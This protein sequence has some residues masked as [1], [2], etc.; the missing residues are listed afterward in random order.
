MPP[1]GRPRTRE[2]FRSAAERAVEKNAPKRRRTFREFL[3]AEIRTDHGKYS[4]SGHRALGQI[5]DE[6]SDV[7]L[8]PRPEI[9]LDILKAE[10]LGLT[11]IGIGFSV[12]AAS[13]HGMNVGYFLP[14][15]NLAGRFGRTK[16]NPA[17]R[18]S[19]GIKRRMRDADDRRGTNQST[20]KEIFDAEG[21]SHFVYALGLKS[22]GNAVMI[23][24]DA[25]IDDEV[26]LIP[27]ENQEWSRGRLTHSPLK[28]RMGISVGMHPGEGIDLRYSEGCQYRWHIRCP[29]CR[30]DFLPEEVFPECVFRAPERRGGAWFLGCVKCGRP[31]DADADGHWFPHFPERRDDGLISYRI[32]QLSVPAISLGWIMS[33]WE[34]AQKKS[35]LMRKFNCAVLARPD[36]GSLEPISEDVLERATGSHLLARA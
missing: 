31:V 27:Q 24:L 34:D 17:I 6:L 16:I 33:R 19:P 29:G 36:A 35:S 11:T 30:K 12:W 23:P 8:L 9:R 26:D 20:L 7:I 21:N 1:K 28:F 2:E 4:L 5:I 25:A 22:I 18:K 3:E 13:E 10:Q 14:T 15:D 32:S